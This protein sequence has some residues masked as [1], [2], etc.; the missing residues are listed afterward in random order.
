M[1][2]RINLKV[3]E[4]ILKAKHPRTRVLIT[5]II[6]SEYLKLN[7]PT[8]YLKS[9]FP[10]A[11]SITKA[12]AG[13]LLNAA[14]S[15]KNTVFATIFS[16]FE[17]FSAMGLNHVMWEIFAAV[18]SSVGLSGYFLE[19]V[20]VKGIPRTLCSYH[21]AS[22]GMLLSEI[23]PKPAA[24]VTPSTLCDGNNI[25]PQFL[26]EA[27][28]IPTF[29]IDVPSQLTEENI[30]YV[31]DQLKSLVSFLERVTGKKFNPTRLQKILETENQMQQFY[32]EYRK[33]R[34][35]YLPPTSPGE[36]I[37]FFQAHTFL[38]GTK[39][40]VNFYK[41]VLKFKNRFVPIENKKRVLWLYFMPHYPTHIT[42]ILQKNHIEIVF[43]EVN[44]IWWKK[45]NPERPFHSLAYKLISNPLNLGTEKR[46]E[47][48]KQM[49]EEFKA[50]G[51]INFTPWGCKQSSGALRILEEHLPVPLLNL[52]G[53]CVDVGNYMPGQLR[54]RLESFAESLQ[55]L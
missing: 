16:P 20:E 35:N 14:L 26:E 21:R 29:V 43:E 38:A 25:I 13:R 30:N 9:P 44:H 22:T 8:T 41:S 17:I 1:G 32:T 27:L 40:S 12:M 46:A 45:L 19:T 5:A 6:A 11:V 33:L 52:E 36:R 42:E 10:P 15:P 18:S 37:A 28:E 23:F 7:F 55:K 48:I 24:F 2:N 50:D 31:A 39:L 51:A 4:N 34:K 54:T 53:D 49:V 47:V 3:I